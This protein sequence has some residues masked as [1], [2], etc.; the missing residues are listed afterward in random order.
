MITV[1]ANKAYKND[2]SLKALYEIQFYYLHTNYDPH[3]HNH[4]MNKI[5]A[6]IFPYFYGKLHY[7]LPS[8]AT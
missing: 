6:H 7:F 2:D 1:T 4:F 8:L 3:N 5:N